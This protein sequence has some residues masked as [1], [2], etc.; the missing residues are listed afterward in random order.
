[1]K[2]MIA[3]AGILLGASSFAIAENHQSPAEQR[4]SLMSG[5]GKQTRPL[6]QMANGGEIDWATVSEAGAYTSEVASTF[7]DLLVEGSYGAPSTADGDAIAAGMDDILARFK[8]FGEAGQAMT[9]A[10]ANEDAVALKAAFTA[11]AGTCRGCHTE[12]RT[13]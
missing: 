11:Y 10:A 8:A 1:M 2:Y 3:A 9:D 12:Y 6:G 7:P 13:N 5:I 4:M